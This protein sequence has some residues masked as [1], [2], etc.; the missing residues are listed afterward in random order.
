MNSYGEAVDVLYRENTFTFPKLGE[1]LK[2]SMTVLPERMALIK[3]VQW[4]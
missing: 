1:V 2:L 4:K 3:S